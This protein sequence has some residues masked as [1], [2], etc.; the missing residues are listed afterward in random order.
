[1][2][3]SSSVSFYFEIFI[4]L[5]LT[6]INGFFACSEMA[7]ASINKNKIKILATKSNDKKA[8]IIFNLLNEPTK[9]LSTIQ[10]A[11]TLAGFL[12]SASAATNFS[13]GLQIYLKKLGLPSSNLI[14]L[15]I[16]TLILSYFTLVLGEL[17]PKRIALENP[18]KIARKTVSVIL[19]ISKLLTP[20]VFFLTLST[21]IILKI[22]RVNSK[23]LQ[24]NTSEEEIKSLL[25]LGRVNGIVNQDEEQMINSIF[26]FKDKSANEIMV[27]RVDAFTI[28][29][30]LP[31]EEQLTLIFEQGYSRVPVYEDD[32]DNIIGILNI[33]DLAKK[34]HETNFNLVEIKKLLKK[35]HFVPEYIKIRQLFKDLK[36]SKKYM[37]ILVDEYGGFSGIVTMEDLVEEIVGEIEDEYDTETTIDEISNGRYIV[38]GKFPLDDLNEFLNIDLQ[39]K[40]NNT[41]AGYVIEKLEC[42]PDK[43]LINK[44]ISEE[45]FIIIIK[46]I[47]EN[48]IEKLE[49]LLKK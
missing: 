19:F 33:K 46:E 13:H 7:I 6:F 1:M 4:L 26:Q 8:K 27:S 16:V 44:E 22:C 49:I 28:N 5:F 34:A 10:V 43:N 12:A 30:N 18:E 38:N 32:I 41:I 25:N 37:A 3:D 29:I 35:P 40:N 14:A 45:S 15:T 20:F 48:R 23:E 47:N 36:I 24:E 9:F 2:E 11:I 39:S 31:L 21:N 17:V 42:I